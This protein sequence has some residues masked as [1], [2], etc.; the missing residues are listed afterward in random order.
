MQIPSRGPGQ[1]P[2]NRWANSGARLVRLVQPRPAWGVPKSA[3]AG[4]GPVT[5][6]GNLVKHGV[7]KSSTMKGAQALAGE[8]YR[9]RC[10]IAK[11][12]RRWVSGRFSFRP[13]EISNVMAITPRRSGKLCPGGSLG[14]TTM[15]RGVTPSSNVNDRA[16]I[17]TNPGSTAAAGV[18]PGAWSRDWFAEGRPG[19]SKAVVWECAASR[20]PSRGTERCP[21]Q[22][23]GGSFVWP[24]RANRVCSM[25][26][27]SGWCRTR[28]RRRKRRRVFYYTR[29]DGV[30]AWQ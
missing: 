11:N 1:S 22:G 19:D 29:L 24:M 2:P 15:T 7:A 30:P 9:R 4:T 12:H 26:H 13:A 8:F 14:H 28:M 27:V 20:S 5:G 23:S 6:F 17:I 16:K 25:A 3:T 18:V 10:R 21:L